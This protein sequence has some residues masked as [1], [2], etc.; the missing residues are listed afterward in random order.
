MKG[1]WNEKVLTAMESQL[2]AR[3]LAHP[4]QSVGLYVIGWY[5]CPQWSG[6]KVAKTHCE[7]LG[8]PETA[9]EFF[10]NQAELLSKNGKLIR[11]YILD[12]RLR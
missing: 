2:L 6:K 10:R 3:Y 4:D 9:A 11:S 12:V 7:Q 8:S 5:L 1:C